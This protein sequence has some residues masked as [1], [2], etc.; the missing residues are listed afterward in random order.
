MIRFLA[1]CCFLALNLAPAMADDVTEE[2]YLNCDDRAQFIRLALDPQAK[3]VWFVRLDEQGRPDRRLPPEFRVNEGKIIEVKPFSCRGCFEFKFTLS[4]RQQFPIILAKTGYVGR[5]L[6][7][8]LFDVADPNDP[9]Q[10]WND[11]PCW[12]RR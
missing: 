12:V 8:D 4:E 11:I 10:T 7:V 1:F 2:S 9:E 6:V 5:N 3:R